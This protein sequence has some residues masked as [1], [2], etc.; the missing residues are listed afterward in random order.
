MDLFELSSACLGE[1]NEISHRFSI[2]NCEIT[3]QT[4]VCQ[5]KNFVEYNEV[6]VLEVSTKSKNDSLY[7]SYYTGGQCDFFVFLIKKLVLSSDF[8]CVDDSSFGDGMVDDEAVGPCKPNFVGEQ[9]AVCRATGIWELLRDGCILKPIGE[10]LE[11]S[12]VT[13]LHHF[14]LASTVFLYDH[15]QH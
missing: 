11:Q 7:N 4:F 10:L 9:V 2:T 6:I 13:Y 8:V 1:G 3:Q 12:Q 15:F 5:E 14:R